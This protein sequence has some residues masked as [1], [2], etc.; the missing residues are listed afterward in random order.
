MIREFRLAPAGA[1][2]GV[3]CDSSGAFVGMTPLLERSQED[4]RDR[5]EPRDCEQLSKQIGSDFGL[6]IDMSSKRGGLKA[7][8]N[9]LNEGDVARAQIATVLLGIPDP[10]PLDG[11]ARSRDTMIKFIRDLHWSG[12]IAWDDAKADAHCLQSRTTA[13]SGSEDALVKAGYNSDEPRDWHGDW[14]RDGGSDGD[15]PNA[16][17]AVHSDDAVLD[18]AVYHPGIDPVDLEDVGDPKQLLLNQLR[19]RAQVQKEMAQWRKKGFWVT[20]N[21]MFV[22]PRP[23]TPIV[24][25]YVVSI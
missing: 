17:I 10:P 12:M 19:H 9:A 22:D 1:K 11:G 18:S 3:S 6:P 7:I 23:D 4:G 13:L 5:W 8:C 14:T 21:V 25:D 15:I 20:P 24:S 2:Q 16:D